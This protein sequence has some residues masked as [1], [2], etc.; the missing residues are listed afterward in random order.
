[1]KLKQKISEDLDI[2]IGMIDEAINA[3]RR[4]VKHIKMRKRNGEIRTVVQPSRKLKVIQYWLMR[5]AFSAMKIH[6]CAMAYRKMLSIKDNAERHIGQRYFLKLDFKDFFPSVEYKDLKPMLSSWHT[7]THPEWD[8]DEEAEEIIR[9]ACFY[10]GDRLPIGYPSSPV[11]SNVVMYDFDV[12]VLSKLSDEKSKYGD[13]VYTRYADDMVFSTNRKG[14][15]KKIY[16]CVKA[17]VKQWKSPKLTINDAKTRYVSSSGG[18][19]LIT[20]LRICYDGHVTLHRSYK[21][22]IRLLV[23]LYDKGKLRKEDVASLR[24]HLAYAR[25]VD[26]VFFTK[27]QNKYFKTLERFESAGELGSDQVK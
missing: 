3:A 4:L 12:H 19:A 11:I 13:V 21:D 7:S 26:S 15:C 8:F 22:K 24:G 20:G 6:E 23:S 25:H 18:S 9:K 1:M 14:A 5:N 17:E 2:P 16:K 10:K 27:L